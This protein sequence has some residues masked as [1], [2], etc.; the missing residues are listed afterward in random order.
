V[1]YSESVSSP[2][3]R[4]L[5]FATAGPIGEQV[6]GK[7]SMKGTMAGARD[8]DPR[9]RVEAEFASAVIQRP[10]V[11]GELTGAAAENS[12]QYKAV[13]AFLD[14]CRK[15]DADAI[16]NSVGPP[17]QETF[18]GMLAGNKAE[19]LNMLADMAAETA[20]LKLTKVTVRGD[21]AEIDFGDGRQTM[22]VARYNGAWK[23]AQ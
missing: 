13:L 8:A 10:A 2:E 14:A 15:K 21:S 20:K 4:T 16:L 22:N 17:S 6:A 12:P 9:W 23:M 5:L 3:D 1:F 19:A 11:S 18:K 7:V